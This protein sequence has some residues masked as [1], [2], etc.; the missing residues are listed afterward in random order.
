MKKTLAEKIANH[1]F[2][3]VV[4][5][6]DIRENDFGFEGTFNNCEM[7]VRVF[8]TNDNRIMI[9]LYVTFFDGTYIEPD[10]IIK[11]QTL[12]SVNAWILTE[13]RLNK[14]G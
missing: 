2:G 8:F 5:A 13:E 12:E 10:F 7:Q 6:T 14:A 3:R 11:G 9:E 1:F 4:F